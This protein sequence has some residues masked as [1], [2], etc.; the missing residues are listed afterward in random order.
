MGRRR[1]HDL[2]TLE[3]VLAGAE[4]HT[5]CDGGFAEDARRWMVNN[6][7]LA[8]FWIAGLVGTGWL[9]RDQRRQLARSSS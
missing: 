1:A 2:T 7:W 3:D 8:V 6:G 5:Y 4:A 9:I